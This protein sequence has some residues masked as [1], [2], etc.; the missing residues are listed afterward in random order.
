MSHTTLIVPYDE[1][2]AI[3]QSVNECA[4]P[5]DTLCGWVT[6]MCDPCHHSLAEP[7]GV[8]VGASQMGRADAFVVGCRKVVG[9]V[10]MLSVIPLKSFRAPSQFAVAIKAVR[11]VHTLCPNG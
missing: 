11:D 8:G 9:L 10:W 2:R 7:D 4:V 5:L 6:Q 1:P 3:K